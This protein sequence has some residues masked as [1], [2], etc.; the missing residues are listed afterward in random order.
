MYTCICEYECVNGSLIYNRF[1]VNSYRYYIE[2]TGTISDRAIGRYLA[3]DVEIHVE[4]VF[5]CST[6]LTT[7]KTYLSTRYMYIKFLSSSSCK[8]EF[9]LGPDVIRY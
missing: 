4:V 8:T 2:E 7:V 6:Y 3:V 1:T 5:S 9:K